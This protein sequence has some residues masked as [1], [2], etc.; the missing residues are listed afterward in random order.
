MGSVP[1]IVVSHPDVNIGAVRF[2][3]VPWLAI[4][5]KYAHRPWLVPVRREGMPRRL[6]G[7]PSKEI[8]DTLDS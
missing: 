3:D 5:A 7:R 6:Q 1:K 4:A 8:I 2:P